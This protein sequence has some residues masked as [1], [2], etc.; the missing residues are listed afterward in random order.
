MV[1]RGLRIAVWVVVLMAY[2]QGALA[3]LQFDVFPG[4]DGVIPQA[5]WFPVVC[6]AKNDGPTFT[7]TVEVAP[8][9]LGAGATY[10]LK[11]ELPTG[12]LKRFEI[13]VFSDPGAGN[14]DVKLLDA[15]GKVRS[16]Q[17]GISSR[18]PVSTETP[19][20]GALAR[21][22]EG[23]PM[24]K[25]ISDPQSYL[26]PVVARLLP[27]IFP[28]N[29]LTLQ[30]MKSL[31][32]SSERATQL[33][34]HQADAIL[35]WVEAGGHLVVGVDQLTDINATRWLRALVPCDLSDIRTIKH[36][37]ELDDWLFNTKSPATLGAFTPPG[38]GRYGPWANRGPR[39][40]S[41]SSPV[42]GGLGLGPFVDLKADPAFRSAELEVAVGN[43]REGSAEISAGD[44]PLVVTANRGCGRVTLLTFSPE[45]EPFLSWKNLPSFWAKIMDVPRA[46]YVTK[47][48]GWAGGW[49]SDGVFGAMI[50]SRQV[51]T[52][53]IEWLLLLLIVY[54]VVI[55]P[56][57]QYWLKKIGRPMLTWITFPCYVVLFS[58]LIYGIGYKLRAG[59]SEWNE[60]HLVDVLANGRQVELRGRTYASVYSPANQKYP[61]RGQENYAAVRGEFYPSW[62]GSA[63]SDNRT[64]VALDGDTFEAQIF[65]PVWLPELFESDWLQAGSAPLTTS[66]TR[67][68]GGWR[69]KVVNRT[70]RKL[71]NLKL[72]VGNRVIDL[73]DL[74]RNGMIQENLANGDGMPLQEFVTQYGGSFQ[75]AVQARQ[76]AFGSTRQRQIGDMPNTTVAASFLSELGSPGFISPPGLDMTPFI[77]RGGAVLL[78][79]DA[80]YSPVKPMNQFTPRRHHRNTLWRI[81]LTVQ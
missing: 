70:S 33:N 66:L 35:A 60:L 69:L 28:D 59:D 16:E 81:P 78:A 23:M 1:G 67:R 31:Y 25:P 62:R 17:I 55:G 68:N 8:G 63:Q 72:V 71:E 38:P 24:V 10:R 41:P 6:E 46:L 12:T 49:S 47:N 73:G 15:R 42:S 57:D 65:V 53:P 61:L 21:T 27:P 7:A 11:V 76:R 79:W 9:N 22:A 36:G 29:P 80:D 34:P 40:P 48:V 50:D 14:W 4:Y 51:H 43:V 19:I 44:T 32:L 37:S 39:P 64:L 52:L 3:D 30:G 13:P 26:R 5:S 20:L 18:K 77:K 56:F 2:A 58:L 74:M 45:R 75:A 54:L